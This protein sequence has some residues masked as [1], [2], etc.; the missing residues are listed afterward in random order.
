MRKEID[1]VF[2]KYM[3]G[4]ASLQ[5]REELLKWIAEDGKLQLWLEERFASSANE[6]DQTLK[7]GLLN[8]IHQQMEHKPRRVAFWP[9]F[10]KVAAI[11]LLPLIVALVMLS[12]TPEKPAVQYCTIEAKK[13]QKSNVILP[14]GS[15]VQ[16]NSESKLTYGTDFNQNNR[17]LKLSGEAY[18]EVA[19]NK[20]CPFIVNTGNL[21]VRALGTAFNIKA[22]NT[23]CS[24]SAILTKG[25]VRVSS[26]TQSVDLTPNEQ[27]EL[28]KGT[29]KLTVT[30]LD[31]ALKSI[32]W[33]NNQLHFNNC[34]FEEMVA[35]LSRIYNIEIYFNS[36]SIKK[37]RF[38]GTINNS[39]IESLFKILSLSAPIRYELKNGKVMLYE[40]MEQKKYYRQ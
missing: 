36:E 29:G 8:R 22:Y 2:S 19:K 5:E 1:L 20:E 25:K 21:S 34:T 10:Q 38:S 30:K 14:D 13:G 9:L 31:N 16:L 4:K 12:I 32:G 40:D 33:L 11:L 3:A 15:R 17:L 26:L 23:D 39:S 6:M 28:N 37:Q 27:V 24:V 18:F 35:S 7:A